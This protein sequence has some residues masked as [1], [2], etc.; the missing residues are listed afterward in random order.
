M[1]VE[2]PP[3][4]DLDAGPDDRL[5]E[6]DPEPSVPP[7]PVAGPVIGVIASALAVPVGLWLVLAP[8][9][10][11]YRHHG[12]PP[13]S[14]AISVATGAAAA[15]IAII[16]GLRFSATLVS[17]LR[18]TGAL[19]DRRAAAYEAAAPPQPEPH[20]VPAFTAPPAPPQPEPSGASGEL[21]ELLAPLVAALAADL[22]SRKG[23]AP[24]EGG[25]R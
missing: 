15:L 12:E 7:A 24:Y 10:F 9:A 23:G 2:A 19:R 20:S 6:P 18:S 21:H 17:R 8:F 13:K 1:T 5:L 3:Y 22:R 25:A 16:S 14:V 11:G 4:D